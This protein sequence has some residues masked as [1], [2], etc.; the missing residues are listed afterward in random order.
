MC[1]YMPRTILSNLS[2]LVV[3][4]QRLYDAQIAGGWQTNTN[5]LNAALSDLS[6][7]ISKVSLW[8]MS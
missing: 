6:I 2:V 1:T 4:R 8:V 7:L 3:A 5:V